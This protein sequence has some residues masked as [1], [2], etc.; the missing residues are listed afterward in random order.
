MLSR[1]IDFFTNDLQPGHPYIVGL[2]MPRSM[3]RLWADPGTYGR[4]AQFFLQ[5]GTEIPH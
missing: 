2:M 5:V 4:A 1:F 3:Q